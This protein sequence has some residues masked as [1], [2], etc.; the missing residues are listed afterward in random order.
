M[1]D[2]YVE[3][4]KAFFDEA[5][6]QVRQ[7]RAGRRG[8]RRAARRPDAMAAVDVAG[9]FETIRRLLRPAG[10]PG[11]GARPDGRRGGAAVAARLR[12][13]R[14]Q[15][16]HRRGRAFPARRSAGHGGAQAA[17]GEPVGPGR[18]GRGA[19]RLS[20]GLPL[21]AALRLARAGGVRG[22]AGGGSGGLRPRPA[23]R[24]H[25]L[26]ARAGRRSPRRCW[27]GCRR[28]EAC[29]ASRRAAGRPGLVTGTIG[30]GWLGLE[31]A[32]RDGCRWSRS[33]SRPW[34]SA[35]ACRCR[36]STSAR[37]SRELADRG[38]GRLG[39]PDRRRR[40]H[41]RGQRGAGSSWIWKRR[42]CRRPAQ[43]WLDARIDRAGG[44]GD[45]GHRAATTTRSPDRAS[46]A[47]RRRL[48][49]EAERL[50]LRLTRIGGWWRAR[51]WGRAIGGQAGR[52]SRG[53]AGPTADNE[54]STAV[55][56]TVAACCRRDLFAASEPWPSP[57]SRRAASRPRMRRPAA[58][59]ASTSPGV[60]LPI[61]VDGR[62]RNYVFVDRAAERWAAG[63]TPETCG[64]RSPTSA[65]PWCRPRIARPSPW[66]TTG[67]LSTRPAI[68]AML[69]RAA[70]RD[71]RR[72]RRGRRRRGR[73]ADA[74]AGV[75]A[76]AR[77]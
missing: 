9:E 70:R 68:S 36:G 65:T 24:R 4:A 29:R 27:A 44:A 45:A 37:R 30:D 2:E 67:P 46:A 6:G 77:G 66:P 20:A 42:R 26:D 60:G 76:C 73:P 40:P 74:R 38:D 50:H 21:V 25:R 33:G 48:R 43:A 55:A 11:L 58:R 14:D 64:P 56:A 69:M 18:Q 5:R 57:R 63:Q 52:R 35:T 16:R 13:G 19:V 41:R 15:G 7:R 49:R 32:R 39:R 31:A 53:R 22:G 12:P 51:G 10:A 23:G 47:T 71:Y 62:L 3:L 34:P 61:I 1:I 75:R 8:P 28:A 59:R 17:A 54:I 72:C